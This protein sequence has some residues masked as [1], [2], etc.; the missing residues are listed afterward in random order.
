MFVYEALNECRLAA[1]SLPGI[2][3]GFDPGSKLT[4]GTLHNS[5]EELEPR[6]WVVFLVAPA[7]TRFL[8]S[9]VVPGASLLDKAL[10]TNVAPYFEASLIKQGES[11]ESRCSPVTV[12]EG[13]YPE[14]VQDGQWNMCSGR[15]GS[16]AMN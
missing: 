12:V 2:T 6:E 14:V 1:A 4:V 3:S 11:P 15:I 5:P 9:L 13:M 8:Q 10:N 7:D 16:E